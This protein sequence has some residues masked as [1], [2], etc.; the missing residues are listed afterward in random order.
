MKPS[1][2][3]PDIE[4]AALERLLKRAFGSATP[5]DYERTRDGVSTQVYRLHRGSNVFYLRVAEEEYENQTVDAELHRQLRHRGVRVPDVV[6]VE[7]FDPVLRRSV[8]ITS[9]VPGLPLAQAKSAAAAASVARAA[10]RDLAILNQMPVDGFAWIRRDRLAWPLVGE[11]ATYGEF[12]TSYLPDN[13]PGELQSLFSTVHLG[14]IEGIIAVERQR[15]LVHGQLA[16]GDFDT[17]AIFQENGQYTGFID[18]G[19]IGGT[20]PFFDLGHFYLHDGETFPALLLQHLIEGYQEVVVLPPDHLDQI[21][22]SAILL[23]L[24][25]L[26]RW[27]GSERARPLNH[28]AVRHRARRLAEMLNQS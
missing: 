27:I 5:I 6:Y 4:R 26:S 19:E 11:L 17:T 8:L 22:R 13:W 12:V 2:R 15:P 18:F 21:R 1:D 3:K 28:P 25:Q 20:E 16:H 24:R 10:G 23:G 14:A 7:P 9:E